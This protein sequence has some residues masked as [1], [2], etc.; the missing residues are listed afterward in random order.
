MTTSTKILLAFLLLVA[1]F[2]GG[3]FL[4][5]GEKQIVEHVTE[6]K[7]RVVTKTRTVTVTKVI[8][9]DGTIEEKTETKDSQADKETKKTET[10]KESKPALA[11]YRVGAKYWLD[12]KTI[13]DWQYRQVE[14][15]GARRLLGDVWGEVGILPIKREVSVG[16]SVQF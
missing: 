3:F 11:D 4:G 16:L 15:T 12:G 2:A 13:G 10:S 9:P 5:K 7:E 8:R 6:G 1:A 14:V